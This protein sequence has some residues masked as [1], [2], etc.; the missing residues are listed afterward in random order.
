MSKYSAW[1]GPVARGVI[2]T[3]PEDFEVEEI[4]GYEPDGAGEH[5]WLWV[6]KI[7]Q[8]TAYVA[9]QLARLAGISARN[10]SFAGLKDR[11]AR[12][13]QYFSLHLPGQPNPDWQNWDTQ[14]FT[15]HHAK[16]ASRK[17]QRGR[18]HG[19]QFRLLIR[20]IHPLESQDQDTHDWSRTNHGCPSSLEQRLRCLAEK[21]MPNF[22]GEQ[23]FG[24][25][26]VGRARRLFAGELRGKR[27]KPKRGYYLSAAR[28]LIFNEFLAERLQQGTWN[29]I[30]NGDLLM[31]DG[32]RS[33]FAAK[34]GDDWDELTQR[35]QQLDLHPTGPLVGEQPSAAS[36]EVAALEEAI[37]ARHP[38][39]I[40][41]LV[42]FRLQTQRRPLR[43]RIHHLQWCWMPPD[44][45][46]LKFTLDSG[47][48]AT[49]LLH[50]L[51]E[52]PI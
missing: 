17:I 29:Q 42:Q 30:V 6:E 8:N 20:D 15:V 13:R 12:T 47:S 24:G 27:S 9:E 1:G 45:L 39:L 21:G 19:N 10:V 31:L 2:R 7:N 50:E 14:E 51:I 43:A 5:L 26:N 52:Y 38:E 4:L 48:Y 37:C 18:L 35:C 16:R 41:G 32:S 44:Q 46:E 28:S 25:N 23:R 34:P 22:F 49:T 33:W 11:N 3:Q 40:E 36:A